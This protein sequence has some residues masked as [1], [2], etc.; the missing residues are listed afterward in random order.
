MKWPRWTVKWPRWMRPPRGWT[1]LGE[2]T[3]QQ[4]DGEVVVPSKTAWD[5]LQLLIVPAFLVAAV[6]IY[7]YVQTGQQNSRSLQTAQDATLDAYFLQMS[8]LMLHNGLLT[9]NPPQGRKGGR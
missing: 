8:G 2:R 9:A 6:T 4:R 1:G 7:N 3:Y 5:W